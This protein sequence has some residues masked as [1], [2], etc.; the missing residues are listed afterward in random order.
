[1]VIPQKEIASTWCAFGAAVRRHP[2]R[3]RAGGHPAESR[4]MPR[5]SMRALDSARSEGERADG[6]ATASTKRAGASRSRS[7]CATAGQINEVE[8]M[9]PEK[10]AEGRVLRQPLRRRFTT[11]YE[12]LYGRGSVLRRTRGWRS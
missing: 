10:R 9:L 11:R 1:M 2:A 4:S 5:A 6:H 3:L 8:V 12:Q 7:T